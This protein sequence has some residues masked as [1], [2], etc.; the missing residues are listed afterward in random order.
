MNAFLPRLMKIKFFLVISY[1][2]FLLITTPGAA[3][4]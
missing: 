2:R 1:L 4:L 3:N